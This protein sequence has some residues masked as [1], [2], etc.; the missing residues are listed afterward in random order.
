MDCYM[1]ELDGFETTRKIRV[2]EQSRQHSKRVPIVAL[3]DAALEGDRERCIEAG[4]DEYLSKPFT[5]DELADVLARIV[6]QDTPRG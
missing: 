3:T 5:Q 4:M 2:L 6:R 1:P